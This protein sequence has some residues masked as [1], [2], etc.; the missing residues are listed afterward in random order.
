MLKQC[1]NNGDL[2]KDCLAILEDRMMRDFNKKQLY[3][4]QLKKDRETGIWTLH[5][6]RDP[7]NLNKRRKKMGLEPI[8]EYLKGLDIEYDLAGVF[9]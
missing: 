4:S 2:K 5:P 8:E 3:G 7:E 6:V 9:D 1:V